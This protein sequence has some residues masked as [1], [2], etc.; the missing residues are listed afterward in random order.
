M[1]K[2]LL[3]LKSIT[4]QSTTK[5]DTSNGL[6]LSWYFDSFKQN[7]QQTD[8]TVAVPDETKFIEL[9]RSYAEK[10]HEIMQPTK[11]VKRFLGNCS[12]KPLPPQVGRCSKGMPSFK[13][14]DYV[15]VSQRN[16]DKEY[17]DISH[18][19]PVY[20]EDG[21]I[22]YCG[23]NKPSVDTPIQLMLYKTLPNIR[24]MIH[25]HCYAEN[26]VMTTKSILCGAIEEVDEV[27]QTKCLKKCESSC[28][29]NIFSTIIIA[30]N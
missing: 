6:V 12:A 18:F 26:A 4:R 1:K 23:D 22:Y 21:K 19:V 8:N 24:Y 20:E 10:F 3:Y 17:L 7:M 14:K 30:L 29:N 2:L 25:S 16:V 15:F 27:L 13:T 11:D 5:S 28:K 9:V